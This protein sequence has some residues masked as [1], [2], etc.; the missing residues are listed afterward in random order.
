MN[1]RFEAK[2]ARILNSLNADALSY[3]DA[4]PKG[5]VDDGIRELISLINNNEHYVTTSSCAGR[6]AVFLDGNRLA[7]AEALGTHSSISHASSTVPNERALSENMSSGK[8]NGGCWL[9]VSHAK[10]DLASKNFNEMF[11]LPDHRNAI[12]NGQLMGSRFRFVHLKFE[13]MVSEVFHYRS[14]V[15]QSVTRNS[16]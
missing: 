12:N 1:P 9:F 8:G 6:V 16:F 3:E 13:P 4:S 2:K 7:D 11:G 10:L 15:A 5:S 14:T